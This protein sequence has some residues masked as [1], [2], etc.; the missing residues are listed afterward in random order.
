MNSVIKHLTAISVAGLLS[1][2][3]LAASTSPDKPFEG[4]TVEG[5]VTVDQF[6]A[7]VQGGSVA[8]QGDGESAMARASRLSASQ[9]SEIAEKAIPGK[10]VE[11]RLDNENGFLVWET[12]VVGANGDETQLKIDAGNGRLLAIESGEKG[13]DETADDREQGD[14]EGHSRWKFWERK[15]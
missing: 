5:G 15:D 2:T 4:V 13:S 1:G 7:E 8:S 11:T 6:P 3:A 12:S 9:A 14:E 10:V